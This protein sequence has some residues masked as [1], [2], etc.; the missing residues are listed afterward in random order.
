MTKWDGN[1]ERRKHERRADWCDGVCAQHEIIQNGTKE[2]RQIVCNK[3]AEVKVAMEQK[4]NNSDLRG[5]MKFVSVLVAIC[6]LIVAGQAIWLKSDISSIMSSI[7]RLNV[8]VTE[9][10]AERIKTDI[11]QTHQL[12]T[13]S[14]ILGTINWRLTEL[15]ANHKAGYGGKN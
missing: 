13:I 9:S 8:R 1:T 15:E 5:L 12:D 3:I 2:H 6:C 14:G 11:E 4:A 7:Q 10:T